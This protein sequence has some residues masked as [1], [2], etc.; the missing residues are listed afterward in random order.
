[1]RA[2]KVTIALLYIFLLAVMVSWQDELNT[3]STTLRLGFLGLSI[4]PAF[5]FKQYKFLPV[6]IALF[7]TINYFGTALSYYP[8]YTYYYTGLV[9]IAYFLCKGARQKNW[10]MAPPWPLLVLIPLILF[11]DLITGIEVRDTLYCLIFLALSLFLYPKL[12]DNNSV[13]L[14]FKL[15][16]IVSTIV[17]CTEFLT[18][19]QKFLVSYD[20]TGN[21]ER[22]RWTDPNYFGCVVGMGTIIA[23]IELL[24]PYKKNM[25]EKALFIGTLGLS[26]AV[27]I[28]NAS[29]GALLAT[30]AGVTYYVIVSKSR[31]WVKILT[32]LGGVFF[33]GYLYR[34][35]YFDLLEARMDVDLQTG[36]GRT[37]IWTTKLHA[38][39]GQSNPLQL[40]FGHGGLGGLCLGYGGIQ[41]FHNE[42]IAM[43][44]EYGILGFIS[45]A[46]LLY[47]P[48]KKAKQN[49]GVAVMV[50]Y[51]VVVCMTLEPITSG[52]ITYYCFL[53][54][55]M[56][57][58]STTIGQTGIRIWR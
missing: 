36:N 41:G 20:V 23:A 1:M 56:I 47:Y 49:R 53:L 35:S 3:P 33:I 30:A 39:W 6:V 54:L 25:L 16:F 4:A 19:G 40:L 18:F 27:L 2:K 21:L 9:F 43:L 17:L 13:I 52:Y 58:S 22:E 57:I 28:M 7:F 51:F 5:I 15:A 12:T 34:N 26:I 10:H 14:L 31:T 11:N 24:T 42:Y 37:V 38:F 48:I 8:T 44:V 46:S 32:I 45:F 50:I 55:I 29:R